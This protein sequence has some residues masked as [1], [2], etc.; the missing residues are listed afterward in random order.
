MWQKFTEAARK[1]VFYAQQIAAERN[2][3]RVAPEHLLLA[4]LRDRICAG[5]RI[6]E[7]LGFDCD[8]L[9]RDLSQAAPEGA[10][11]AGS[12]MQ[13]SHEAKRA[14]DFAYDEAS[15]ANQS[16]IGTEHILLGIL[17]VNA[18]FDPFLTDPAWDLDRAREA[19][20]ELQNERQEGARASE[21]DLFLS[22]LFDTLTPQ[23]Q[24]VVRRLIDD[25]TALLDTQL[26]PASF[27]HLLLTSGP[28]MAVERLARTGFEADQIAELFARAPAPRAETV[29]WASH[30]VLSRLTAG[31]QA[32]AGILRMAY[33]NALA[34]GF[35]R[36][37]TDH[38]LVAS[39][40]E[41]ERAGIP[42]V[43]RFQEIGFTSERLIEAPRLKPAQ[44]RGRQREEAPQPSGP[45]GD[46]AHGA[47]RTLLNEV[48]RINARA[49]S[50]QEGASRLLKSAADA[51]AKLDRLLK[52]RLPAAPAT[53]GD[54]AG[55]AGGGPDLALQTRATLNRAVEEALRDNAEQVL[56]RHVL[57]ALLKTGGPIVSVL[58]DTIGLDYEIASGML[59]QFDDR[60]IADDE[61]NQEGESP[62]QDASDL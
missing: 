30:V 31:R 46:Q 39:L 20:A 59:E 22:D 58:F 44:S 13:L 1:A 7:A 50:M 4:I 28:N 36:A 62:D 54:L 26:V 15:R 10:G 14:V 35:D 2:C 3:R 61:D 12:D 56:P 48:E 17:D 9:A 52:Q 49:M 57:L 34:F 11:A 40:K 19:A 29:D 43:Q 42:V 47:D 60:G 23:L 55:G 21:T 24:R 51:S 8:T 5:A 38:A 16:Y 53:L 6:V 32:A 33:G 18:E 37:D 27:L 25:P 41:T 45:A